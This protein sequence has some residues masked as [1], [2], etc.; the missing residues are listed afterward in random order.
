MKESN[1]ATGDDD[2][3][4]SETE[5]LAGLRPSRI[6]EVQVGATC[7]S[8]VDLITIE[9]GNGDA[10]RQALETFGLRVNRF[11]VGQ[12]RHLVRHPRVPWRRRQHRVTRVGRGVGAPSAVPRRGSPESLRS[13]A[14]FDGATGCDPGHPAL[15]EAVLGPAPAPTSRQ[16]GACSDTQASSP[17]CS[18]SMSLP[19]QARSP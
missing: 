5:W 16:S 8:E 12:A 17:R 10:L 19:S 1:I 6:R 9:S 18:C 15:V 13:F 11:P 14:R 7:W 2:S 3:M 4:T